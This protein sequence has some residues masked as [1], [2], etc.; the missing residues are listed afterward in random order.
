MHSVAS[1][2][3]LIMKIQL[4]GRALSVLVVDDD[5]DIARTT[6]IILR[7][8]AFEVQ[9][10]LSGLAALESVGERWPDAPPCC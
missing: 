7:Y 5:V 6:A 10:A 4:Q 3:D 9:T 2:D 1:E 8:M